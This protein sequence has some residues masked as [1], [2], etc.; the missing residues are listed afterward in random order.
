MWQAVWAGTVVSEASL[1]TCIREIRYR[2]GERAQAPQ[3]IETVHRRGYRWIAPLPT[4]ALPPR[5]QAKRHGPRRHTAL[6]VVGRAAEFEHLHRCLEQARRGERQVVFVTGEAGMG[7]T[8]LVDAWL[9]RVGTEEELWSAQG[10]CIEHY[11]AGE[12]YLP[13]LEALGRLCRQP[14]QKRLVGLL[15]QYAPTWLVQLPWLLSPAQRATLQREVLGTTRERM[16]REMAEA[17][18]AITAETPLVLVL[19]DLHWSDA[20]TLDLLASLARRREAARLL[21]IGTYRPVEVLVWEHPLRGLTQELQLQGHCTALPLEGLTEAEIAAYLAERFPGSV[22][23]PELERGLYQRT[24]GNPLFMVNVVGSLVTQG[25]LV[26][27]KGRWEF[28]GGVE[29]IEHS[30]PESLRQMIERHI[31]RLS[32]EDQRVLEVASVVGVEFS[33]AAV[34]AGVAAEAQVEERCTELTRRQHFLASRGTSEWPDG[35]VTARYSFLH[36]LYQEVW[37]ERV[38][39]RRR[40]NLHRCIGVRLEAGYG[41]QAGEVAVE[42]AVHFEVGRE[43]QRAVQYLGQAAQRALSRRAYHEAIDHLTRGLAL[44]KT[45]PDTPERAQQEFDLQLALGPVLMATKGQATPEVA[46]TYAR[47]WALCQ[48]IGDTPQRFAALWGLQRFYRGQGAWPT[49]RE[50]GEQLVQLAERDADP[51]RCLEAHDALGMTLFFLGDY[52]AART[53]LAQGCAGTD[54]TAQRDFVRRQ[55]EAPGVR[56]LAFTAWTLWCL[57]YPAQALRRIQEALALAQELAHPYS[58]AGAQAWAATLHYRRREAAAVQA[59][60]EALLTLA[61]AEGFVHFVGMGACWRGWALAMQGQDAAGLAQ[62]RQGIAAVLDAGHTQSRPLC[63]ILLA[64]AMG[65]VGQVEDGLRLLAE[66][67]TVLEAN[68]QGDLLAE[69]YR[70]QGTLLLQQAIPDVVQAEACFQQARTIARNQH[71][72][73]WELRAALSLSRLWQRQGKRQAA[74]DLLAPIYDWFTEGFDTADLQEAEALL[75]ALA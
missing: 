42:L 19:E 11:G 18:E 24:E 31:A 39:G 61:T 30:V 16:L 66:A 37:Y 23:P 54:L 68:G 70:L 20:A 29:A 44:L 2:L 40:I 65:Q 12:A 52:A 4:P 10:Q 25:V 69:V 7:K 5:H 35:T 3:Y 26:Q 73:S 1:T 57:G 41:T 74:S 60:A 9:E 28:A 6:P 34:A 17:L 53:Q 75:A 50:L 27:G 15:R 67:R 64:E 8:T 47:A 32:P 48:Q 38:T 72:K 33:A 56:G 45:L 55:G 51:A 46:Q 22:L 58:L 43:Y 13:V 71:A 36:A 59:Q 49:A 62:L 21:L 63:L 14:G